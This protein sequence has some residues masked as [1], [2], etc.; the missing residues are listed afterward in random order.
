MKDEVNKAIE[1]YSKFE[2]S[3]TRP[4][5]L[6]LFPHPESDEFWKRADTREEKIQLKEARNYRNIYSNALFE[7]KSLAYM[8]LEDAKSIGDIE[9]VA[10]GRCL[11][12]DKHAQVVSYIILTNDKKIHVFIKNNFVTSMGIF[13]AVNSMIKNQNKNYKHLIMDLDD[14]YTCNK[15]VIQPDPFRIF[16]IE[17][18]SIEPFLPANYDHFM[19]KCIE[20]LNQKHDYDN[21]TKNDKYID[22]LIKIKDLFDKGILTEDEFIEQKKHILKSNKNSD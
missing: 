12:C 11:N 15:S 5:Q 17:K 14:F 20:V 2:G 19:N 9:F 18:I 13:G 8:F 21:D 4:E 22:E 16:Q 3:L 10:I 6:P 1:W 7:I